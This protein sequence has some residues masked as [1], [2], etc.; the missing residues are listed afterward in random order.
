MSKEEVMQIVDKV[1]D[2]LRKRYTSE[3][4]LDIIGLMRGYINYELKKEVK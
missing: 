2:D 4:E 3:V 1:C